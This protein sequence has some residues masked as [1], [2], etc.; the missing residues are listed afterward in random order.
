MVEN[1]ELRAIIEA[2]PTEQLQRTHDYIGGQLGLQNQSDAV[3]ESDELR[4]T[5]DELPKNQLQRIHGYISGKLEQGNQNEEGSPD[6]SRTVNKRQYER[7]ECLFQ[8]SFIRHCVQRDDNAVNDGASVVDISQSG[9]LLH[10]QNP[11]EEGELLTV[12][13]KSSGI[14]RKKL[15]LQVRYCNDRWDHFEVGTRIVS[16]SLINE[17]ERARYAPAGR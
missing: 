7:F 11:L 5:L 2:L 17:A 9:A 4:A 15:F 1:D 10:A 3:L 16:Q 13:L 12:F 14:V 6:E 8:A